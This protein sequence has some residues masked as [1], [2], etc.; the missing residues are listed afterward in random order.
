MTVVFAIAEGYDL[1][2][3]AN[4]L[5]PIVGEFGLTP[6]MVGLVVSIFMWAGVL[7]SPLAANFL[8][9]FGRKP[10]IA[11]AAVTIAAG[12][13]CWAFA[14]NIIV[15][16]IGRLIMG[17]GVGMGMVAVTT[18]ICEVA[19]VGS[20]GMYVAVEEFCLNIGI[21]SGL[22]AGA[23]IVGV[24][25]DWRI[26][27]GIGAVLP[28]I[29]AIFAMTP[30]LPES[31]RYLQ[32]SGKIDEAREVLLDL[33]HGDEEEVDKAFAQWKEEARIGQ[34]SMNWSSALGA[35]LGSHFRMA[36]AAIGMGIF[37][38]AV[39]VNIIVNY[40]I[41]VLIKNGMSSKSAAFAMV[42]LGVTKTISVFPGV[43]LMDR[44]GRN[45]LLL[46]S[47][48]ICTCGHIVVAYGN[49]VHLG[50]IWIAIGFGIFFLGF[51]FGIGPV[52]YVYVSEVFDNSIRSKGVSAS[53]VVRGVVGAIWALLYPLVAASTGFSTAYFILAGCSASAFVFFWFFCPETLGVPLENINDV[54][55]VQK[56]TSM[57]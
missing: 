45:P 6:L 48:C 34:N 54:F 33:L 50:A 19:P 14:P 55:N 40:A 15:I 52:Y 20:R 47:A 8:D 11:F 21:L 28:L 39:G 49:L 56:K 53:F 1:G 23:L 57:I 22:A 36:V 42:L 43:V 16:I 3:M 9:S 24:K 13:L 37:F 25:N 31:P 10:S 51:S 32:A 12:N 35:F 41:P 5:A 38:F 2:V 7:A 44:W 30:C 17:G 29:C 27:V 4:A 46:C 18:Y 26:M